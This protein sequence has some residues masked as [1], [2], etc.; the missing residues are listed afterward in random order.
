M[1]ELLGDDLPVFSKFD[2]EMLKNG[3]DFI[4]INH[5]TSFYTKDYMFS[6]CDPARGS[7]RIEGYALQT[8]LKDG[9]YIGEPVCNLISSVLQNHHKTNLL[10]T[11]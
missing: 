1:R 7:S 5:Y 9:V 10:K 6:P 4:G 3:L 11:T 8:A 2:Q